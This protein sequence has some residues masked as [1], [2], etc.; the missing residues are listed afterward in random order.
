[1]PVKI[2]KNRKSEQ[3]RQ[4]KNISKNSADFCNQEKQESKTDL[5]TLLQNSPY[6]HN[7]P[8]IQ[9]HYNNQIRPATQGACYW[10]RAAGDP[11][12]HE[13]KCPRANLPIKATTNG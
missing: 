3:V 12:C 4:Q 8:P 6:T 9:C 7:D 1:M 5:E 10:H 11:V 13:S 2:L